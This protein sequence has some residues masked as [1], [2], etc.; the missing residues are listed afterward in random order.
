MSK[1]TSAPDVST[2]HPNDIG[3][4]GRINGEPAVEIW[5]VA[6]AR[7]AIASTVTVADL[8]IEVR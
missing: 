5:N 6:D 4:K 1:M 3:S 2:G 8:G 7:Q